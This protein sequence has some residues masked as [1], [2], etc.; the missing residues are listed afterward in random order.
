[1]F[2]NVLTV[3]ISFCLADKRLICKVLG[4]VPRHEMIVARILGSEY[5]FIATKVIGTFETLMFIWVLSRK[6]SRLCAVTQIIIVAVMNIIEF[7]L[8]PGSFALWQAECFDSVNVY[9]CGLLQ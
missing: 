4:L 1:M 5:S 3:L 9:C 6:Y 8:A 2:K 7:I